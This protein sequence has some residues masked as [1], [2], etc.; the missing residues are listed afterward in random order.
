LLLA[1]VT[2]L[3]LGGLT[4]CRPGHVPGFDEARAFQDVA[5]QVKFGPRVPGTPAHEAER[6]WLGAPLKA[7][8][9]AGSTQA[10]AD[11]VYDRAYTFSN[12]RARY[13]PTTGTWIVIGAHWDTRP[14]ADQD[15]DTSKRAL[16]IP[17]ANDGGSGV[18][19][20]LG[21]ARAFRAT[22][23]PVGIE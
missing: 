5:T 20:L 15:P 1:T 12:V 23:P 3:A 13:G 2:S 18:A 7:S 21:L 10:F 16:P 14:Y 9:G 6:D 17:G 22:P 19:V 8:G 4:G 11:T